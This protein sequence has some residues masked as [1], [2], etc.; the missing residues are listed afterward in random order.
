M[1]KRNPNPFNNSNTPADLDSKLIESGAEIGEKAQKPKLPK[2]IA[3]KVWDA[4]YTVLGGKRIERI[5]WEER[6]KQIREMEAHL[7]EGCKTIPEGSDPTFKEYRKKRRE[8]KDNGPNKQRVLEQARKDYNALPDK[9][10]TGKPGKNG[11][12]PIDKY[13]DEVFEEDAR[14][15]PEGC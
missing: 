11:E 8:G 7:P 13:V 2:K 14:M 9:L 10:K 3:K 1:P 6:K 15:M 4:V 5:T 12:H